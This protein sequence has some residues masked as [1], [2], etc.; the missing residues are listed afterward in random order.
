M[1][2]ANQ[3]PFDRL[4]RDRI[5]NILYVAVRYGQ[6]GGFAVV[7]IGLPFALLVVGLPIS[8]LLRSK[9]SSDPN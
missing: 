9:Q 6:P 3:G 8:L 1:S 7:T 5:G 4:S 2:T